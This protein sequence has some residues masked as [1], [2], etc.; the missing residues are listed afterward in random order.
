[1][2]EQV[3]LIPKGEVEQ[4]IKL[5]MV[6]LRGSLSWQLRPGKAREV[7]ADAALN[8]VVFIRLYIGDSS[9]NP[10]LMTVE[11]LESNCCWALQISRSTCWYSQR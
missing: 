3:V 6:R 2:N 9:A 8:Q 4:L 11:E 5:M 1:V 10:A 7:F